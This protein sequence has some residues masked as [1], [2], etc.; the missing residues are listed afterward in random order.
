M[1]TRIRTPTLHGAYPCSCTISYFYFT[2][3]YFPSFWGFYFLVVWIIALVCIV[4][5]DLNVRKQAQWTRKKYYIRNLDSHIG[6]LFCFFEGCVTRFLLCFFQT[7][8]RNRSKRALPMRVL[9]TCECGLRKLHQRKLCW[10]VFGWWVS[11]K[12]FSLARVQNILSFARDIAALPTTLHHIP[13][14]SSGQKITYSLPQG[15]QGISIS[16]HNQA[17]FFKLCEGCRC[18]SPP[19]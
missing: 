4:D 7:T 9:C 10:Y 3:L 18:L 12:L 2:S 17:C 8:V 11:K 16:R 6:L 1:G 14:V 5:I 19:P 13:V 15:L